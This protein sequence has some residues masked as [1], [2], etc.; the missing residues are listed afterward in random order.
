MRRL[1]SPKQTL[2][3]L[4][5][6]RSTK[7]PHGRLQR[8][9]F[10]HKRPKQS[11]PSAQLETTLLLASIRLLLL[12]VAFCRFFFV[13]LLWFRSC[14]LVLLSDTL[15]VPLGCSWGP[16]GDSFWFLRGSCWPL[17]S[18]SCQKSG[19]SILLEPAS[20]EMG[21]WRP[22]WRPK[23]PKIAPRGFQEGLGR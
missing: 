8:S 2:S 22:R 17:G 3:P 23:R 9:I 6:T 10:S 14:F 20:L 19:K 7:Q 1:S 5:R 18:S 12:L 4:Q 13:R 11:K 16:L 15:L 21:S